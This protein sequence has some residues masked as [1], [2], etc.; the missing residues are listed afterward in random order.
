MSEEKPDVQK[1]VM[2][3]N[4]PEERNSAELIKFY[5]DMKVEFELKVES[6]PDNMI[7]VEIYGINPKETEQELLDK[8]GIPYDNASDIRH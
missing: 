5:E 3:T 1:I 7:D 8:I 4:D 2:R 6:T